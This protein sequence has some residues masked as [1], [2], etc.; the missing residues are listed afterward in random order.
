M[1]INSIIIVGGG[2][3]GWMT[4]AMLSKHL[5]ETKISLIESNK[6]STIGVGES[7]LQF[8]NRY[9]NRMELKD[10]DWMPYCNATYKTSIGF[11]NFKYGKGERFQYPFGTFNNP[12]LN[13]FFE[14]QLK[15]GKELYP[16]EDFANYVNYNTFIS[17]TNRL[18]VVPNFKFGNFDFN[19]DTAYHLDAELFGKY[20]RDN[21][22]IPNGVNHIVDDVKKF[23]IKSD[24]SLSSL[25]T[26]KGKLLESDL[27]IDCT[28]FKSLLLEKF[29]NVPYISFNNQLLNNRAISVRTPY[30]DVESE[31]KTY[32]DCVAMSA[33]WIWNIPLWHRF[34]RGYCYSSN[35]INE[36][37]AEIEFKN[38]LRQIYTT[39]EIDDFTFNHI[40]IRNGKH[41][42][43]WKKNC[44]A[45]GLSY[46]FLEPLESTGL[47]TTHETI[48]NLCDTL[49]R[50]DRFIS[51]IDVDVFNNEVDNIMEGLKDFVA[52]HYALSQRSDTKYWRDCR[53][54]FTCK[55]QLEKLNN[56]SSG[57]V[58]L[59]YIAAGLGWKP[60]N[61]I[62]NA[63]T[64]VFHEQWQTDKEE[65]LNWMSIQPTHYQYLKESIYSK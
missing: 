39:D 18:P 5:P 1:K 59:L 12:N 9:L 15:Y 26:E 62:L 14:L 40:Q 58:G 13:Q 4:A 28:G 11:K 43:A 23:N 17:D 47:L 20:L 51:R 30:N 46:G 32:T 37:R 60:T 33:G 54:I 2:S 25:L 7:T 57:S 38:Y 19:F 22:C 65:L 53:D 45:I 48:L 56:F 44:V 31:M 35:H 49:L 8:F 52:I 55:K 50:R 6:I 21:I 61:Q 42:I 10:K 34:G 24:G 63:N 16:D 36:S 3:A 64:D 29:M 27:F 41:D